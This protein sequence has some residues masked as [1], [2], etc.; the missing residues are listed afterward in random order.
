MK[1]NG[2]LSKWRRHLSGLTRDRDF[3]GYA[4]E[5]V[6]LL[7]ADEADTVFKTTV[8]EGEWVWKGQ[9]IGEPEG[10]GACIHASITGVVGRRRARP[11]SRSRKR[12]MTARPGNVCG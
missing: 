4:P 2:Q 12:T 1:E 5:K 9:V 7:L 11:G 3:E 10:A 8:S 6:C